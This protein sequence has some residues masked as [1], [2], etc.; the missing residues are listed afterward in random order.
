AVNAGV[1]QLWVRVGDTRLGFYAAPWLNALVPA[2]HA[3]GID[4]IGWGFPHLYDTNADVAWTTDALDWHT[5]DGQRLDGFSA[6]LELST[7]GVVLTARR[8]AYYLQSVRR[9]ADDRPL[10]ATVY[11]PT[12][13]LWTTYPYAAIAPY[14][15]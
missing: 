2:A 15:D 12:D 14:V 7:E 5:A 4:V 11:R 8:A 13:R 9:S 10:V 1:Q 3:R 6:D